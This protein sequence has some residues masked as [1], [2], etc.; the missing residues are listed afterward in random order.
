MTRAVFL[1]ALGTL[2]ELEPPWISL[3]DRVPAE[4][5]DERLVAALRAEMDYYREHAHEGRDEAS[6]AELRERCAA[7]VSEKLDF[8]ITVDELIEAIRFSAYPDAAP[9]LGALRDRGMRLIA[10]SNWDCALPRVLERCG[11][12]RMLDGVVT[13]AE[14]GA[15]KPD[16]AIFTAALELVGC[17]AGE[18]LHVGDTAEEDVAGARAAGIRPLLIDRDGGEGDISS[19]R[20]I[21]QHL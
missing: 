21:D 11:I 8:E 18:A 19:L 7:I 12:E 6:L 3:R 20:E 15:R 9:A 14:A 10:V 5:S 2:V 16:P 1:D 17:E 13:S 4:V